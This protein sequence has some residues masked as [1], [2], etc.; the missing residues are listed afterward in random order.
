[1]KWDTVIE[2]SSVSATG[3]SQSTFSAML[4]F[5]HVIVTR[6]NQLLLGRV[7]SAI[8]SCSARIQ[9]HCRPLVIET[10]GTTFMK[11]SAS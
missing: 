4:G 5:S 2:T 7:F 6:L 9:Q 1:M 11:R 8:C 10:N 3:L